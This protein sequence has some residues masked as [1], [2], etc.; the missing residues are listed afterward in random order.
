MSIRG[1]QASY[2]NQTEA[3]T[4]SVSPML[5]IVELEVEGGR[6]WSTS[7]GEGRDEAFAELTTSLAA[8]SAA[9]VA[10][11]ATSGAG[12]ASRVGMPELT[13]SWA[14][15]T[16]LGRASEDPK[17]SGCGRMGRGAI[18]VVSVC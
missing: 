8:G 16:S 6:T 12:V 14:S 1:V 15:S 11:A 17:Y 18:V 4:T 5:R 13:V 10:A 2:R 7:A 3:R 9:G